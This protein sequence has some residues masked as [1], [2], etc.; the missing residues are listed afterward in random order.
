MCLRSSSRA[1]LCVCVCV[2]VRERERERFHPDINFLMPELIVVTFGMH[3]VV[4]DFI[5]TTQLINLSNH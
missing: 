4:A 3:I 1:R 5:S 2:C